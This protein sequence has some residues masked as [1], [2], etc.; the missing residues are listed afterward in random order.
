MPNHGRARVRED[1]NH[2]GDG[3]G[4]ISDT[5]TPRVGAKAEGGGRAREQD[6][7]VGDGRWNWSFH[8]IGRMLLAG[9]TLSQALGDGRAAV[10]IAG[11]HCSVR[12]DAA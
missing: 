5:A 10:S 9:A 1:T 11:Q 12:A 3:I 8:I 2:L 6:G 4:V 7:G